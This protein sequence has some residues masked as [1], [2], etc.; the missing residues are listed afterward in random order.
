MELR[1][2]HLNANQIKL[3]A[4]IAMTID[5]L[6]W[7]F[8]PGTQAVWYVFALHIIGRL[9]ALGLQPEIETNGAIPLKD[10][11]APCRPK[12]TMDYKLPSSRMEQHM[13]TE[14]FALLHEWDTVKF[15]CGTRADVF[16]AKEIAELYK[17]RCP[18]YLSPVFGQI[19]PAE[20]VEI[21]KEQKMTRFRLQLQLHKF[22]WDPME[23]GV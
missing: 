23:R 13:C 15:V 16:R 4:I 21:M 12:F 10:F 9:T 19:E 5:H 22:I 18:L 6:T 1:K 2:K 3:I 7:A 8:F 11:C 20:I 14:N 17:P